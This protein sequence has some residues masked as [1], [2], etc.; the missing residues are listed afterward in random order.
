ML[1]GCLL[2]RLDSLK[3]ITACHYYNFSILTYSFDEKISQSFLHE[4]FIHDLFMLNKL[5]IT[6]NHQ[7]KI[8]L[9]LLV[10]D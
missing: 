8:S 1:R 9:S 3:E 4:Q 6:E 2:Y 5:C 10:V 7:P